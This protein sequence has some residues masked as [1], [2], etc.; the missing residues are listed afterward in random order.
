MLTVHSME[1]CGIRELDGVSTTAPADVVRQVARMETRIPA[2]LIFT[3]A[4]A[5]NHELGYGW[6]LKQYIEENNFGTVVVTQ[7]RK[8]PNSA[9]KITTFVW[10]PN[11]ARVRKVRG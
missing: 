9:N 4:S 3:Q 6:R 7:P 5:Q 1:C 2:H 8:N 11:K 10:T